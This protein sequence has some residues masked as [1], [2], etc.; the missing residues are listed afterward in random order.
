MGKTVRVVVEGGVIQHVEV[1]EGVVVVV[2]DYDVEGCESN[3]LQRDG[4]GD[5]FAEAIWE[6]EE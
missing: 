2:N 3:D 5:E 1:P 4:N 6:S